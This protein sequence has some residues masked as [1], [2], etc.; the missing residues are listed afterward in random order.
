MATRLAAGRPPFGSLSTRGGQSADK[1][2]CNSDF[3]QL[4]GQTCVRL[5]MSINV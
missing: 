5:I 2:R 4:S 3:V 1:R